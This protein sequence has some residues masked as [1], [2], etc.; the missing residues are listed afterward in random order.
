MYVSTGFENFF[1]KGGGAGQKPPPS[2]KKTSSGDKKASQTTSKQDTKNSDK[3]SSNNNNNRKSKET[4]A[5][6]ELPLEATIIIIINQES[7]MLASAAL[8]ALLGYTAY[9]A[10]NG[11][12]ASSSAKSVEITWQDMYPLL[13]QDQVEKIVVVNK[14]MARVVLKQGAPGLLSTNAANGGSVRRTFCRQQ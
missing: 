7:N 11:K 9:Q 5:L 8:L 3:K 4:R 14:N 6:E 1:P 13:H 10:S 12:D 2:A